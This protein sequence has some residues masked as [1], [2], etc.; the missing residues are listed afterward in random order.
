MM[1]AAGLALC[2]V[3]VFFFSGIETGVL[4]LNRVRV[5]HMKE[6]GL[7]G[8]RLLLGFMHEPGR[9][10]S[11]VLVGKTLVNTV[12]SVLV[13]YK[14]L[15]GGGPWAL[16]CVVPAFTV[17]VWFFGELVPKA[18]FRRFPNR[19][20]TWLAPLLLATYVVLWLIVQ[21][22]DL[23]SRLIIRG[24]KVFA[25]Q[26]FVTREELKL[27]ARE[28]EGNLPLSG[29]QRNLVASIMDTTHAT[30]RDIMRPKSEVVRVKASQ[31]DAERLTL[32]ATFNHSRLPVESEKPVNPGRW[33]GLWV[34]YDR[35][36]EVRSGF[37][38]P[39]CIALTANT[40]EILT[41]LRKARSPLAF[42]RDADGNDV[43]IVT[44]EDVLHR[45]L[46]KV[47]L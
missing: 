24:G 16:V 46:G 14:V 25:R 26:M 19:L 39:P 20:T 43:G 5:R 13:G 42:V 37:R 1:F 33:E 30:A 35:L 32:A 18:L 38:I 4:L 31:T 10:S 29:E 44:V 9:L 27:L 41:E 21:A 47:D 2:L 23:C 22:F 8:A 17:V 28:G 12:A 3:L 7:F 45:Y 6:K 36:F 15:D 11:T 34:V 40:E